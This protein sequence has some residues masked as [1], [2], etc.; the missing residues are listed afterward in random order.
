MLERIL[1]WIVICGVFTVPFIVLVVDYSLSY[2]ASTGKGFAFRVI[3]EVVAGAWFALAFVYEKYRPRR[4]LIL[5]TFALFVTIMAIADAQ[6]VYPYESFWGN[7]ARMDGWVTLIHVFAYLVV[8]SSVIASEKMWK[9][10]F[11]VS[12]G[13]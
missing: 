10:L 6:G 1:R 7:Y 3:V 2:P 11:Q 13:V 12:L 5:G 9:S 4:S 8:A